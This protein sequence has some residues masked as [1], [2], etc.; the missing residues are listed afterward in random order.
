MEPKIDFYNFSCNGGEFQEQFLSSMYSIQICVALLSN[1]FALWLLV[2]RERNNWHTGVV[3]SCNLAISDLLYSL[4]LP[5]LIDYY[6]K[7]R[8]WLNG[9]AACKIERFFFT[10]NL[11]V[12]IYFIMCISVTRYL[13]VAHPFFTRNN[14]SPAR[15]KVASV[16][17]W[18][19][20]T[21]MSSPA[22]RFTSLCPAAYNKTHC[23]MNSF[24]A[25]T[26]PDVANSLFNYKVTLTVVGCFVPFLVTFVSYGGLLRVVWRNPNITSVVKRKVGLMVF[27]AVVL[28]AISFLPYHFIECYYLYARVNDPGSECSFLYKAYQVS[29]GLVTMNMCIHPLLYVAVFDNIRMTCF[30]C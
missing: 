30:S 16:V 29:K 3:L 9:S 10:C 17:I 13:A 18:I 19:S 20:V 28:S 6:I 24:C 21:A 27:A 1:L 22:L 11:Y 15:A 14:V 23:V 4:T 2:T 5:M 25:T 8:D 7:E 26:S 12:S